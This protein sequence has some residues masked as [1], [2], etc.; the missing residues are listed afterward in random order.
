MI[1]EDE[2]YATLFKMCV[3]CVIVR[4]GYLT[5]YDRVKQDVQHVWYIRGI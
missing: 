4:G 3:V 2:L 5:G 1:C